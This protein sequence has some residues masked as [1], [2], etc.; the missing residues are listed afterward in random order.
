MAMRDCVP[1]G[2]PSEEK[3]GTP[4][5]DSPTPAATYGA[6]WP[7][8]GRNHKRLVLVLSAWMRP[9]PRR[10]ATSVSTPSVDV[11]GNVTMVP[12]GDAA[13]EPS[14]TYGVTSTFVASCAP[15]GSAASVSAT[16]AKTAD[17]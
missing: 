9:S 3:T 14:A 2:G 15:A 8:R 6:D 17:L 11:T 1:I 16:S 4:Y 12:I 10:Y 13:A 5:C 7:T